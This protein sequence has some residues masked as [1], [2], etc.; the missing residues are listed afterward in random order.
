M[1][2]YIY[3][4][5][6]YIYFACCASVKKSSCQWSL[7]HGFDP[8]V[9]NIPREGNGNPLQYSC[10]ENSMD[11]RAWEATIHGVAKSQAWLS[12]HTQRGTYDNQAAFSLSLSLSIY[13]YIYFFF[14][15]FPQSL[16]PLLSV[17]LL[18][19]FHFEYMNYFDKWQSIV[20]FY[21][22]ILSA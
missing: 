6:Y 2:V 18:S 4:Y 3:I 10:L 19:H 21:Y 12:S 17:W 22:V 9:G 14:F 5:I 20:K 7:W 1:C 15:S 13:I 11:I 8:R 16:Y